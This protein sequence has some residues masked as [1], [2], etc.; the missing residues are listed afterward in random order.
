MDEVCARRCVKNV[1][2]GGSNTD[3]GDAY[4]NMWVLTLVLRLRTMRITS[5]HPPPLACTGLSDNLSS[6]ALF[7]LCNRTVTNVQTKLFLEKK[8]V[9][10]LQ[11]FIASMKFLPLAI[12]Q[13]ARTEFYGIKISNLALTAFVISNMF[14]NL[15]S[16]HQ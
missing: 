8:R 15:H 16:E 3:A 7:P 5:L 9:H 10:L 1:Y 11:K 13:T 12:T 6:P 2:N 4:I 14:S